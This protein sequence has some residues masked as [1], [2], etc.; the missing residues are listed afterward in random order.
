MYKNGKPYTGFLLTNTPSDGNY[1]VN[2]ALLNAIGRTTLLTFSGPSWPNWNGNSIPTSDAG[3][4]WINGE[5][6]SGESNNKLWSGGEFDP[7]GGDVI[8]NGRLF[9]NGVPFA[10]KLQATNGV[11]TWGNSSYTI[12]NGSSV[13]GDV[14]FAGGIVMNGFNGGKR[15]TKGVLMVANGLTNETFKFNNGVLANGVIS[16]QTYVNGV[17]V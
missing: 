2:G 10:G 6:G 11:V 12:P 3:H 5:V 1:Q 7:N 9:R 15:Y 17:L 14:Y 8:S 16:G 4:Y 13:N